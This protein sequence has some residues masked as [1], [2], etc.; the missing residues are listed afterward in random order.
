VNLDDLLAALDSGQVAGAALDVLPKEPPDPAMPILQHPRV[1]FTPHL[2]AS[3]D[4]A[5]EKVAEMIARQMSDYLGTGVITNAV[6]FPSISREIMEQL[7]PYLNLGERMGSLM[8]QLIRHLHDITITYSGEVAK[9]DTRP[10]THAVLKGLLGAYSDQPV[11]YVSA[12]S[13]ARDKGIKVQETLSRDSKDYTS[14]I[15]LKLEGHE[16]TLNDIWGTIFGKKNPRIVRLGRIYM[17]AMPEGPILVIQNHDK[18]G[19]IGNIGTTLSQHGIN[20]GR[21]QLGRRDG[22][23]LCL[24][25]IDTPVDEKV[26][27]EIRSLPNI[28]MVRQVRLD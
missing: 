22:Q 1:I 23:A 4:E 11:N 9:L 7:R 8:G 20:I 14:L 27:E 2:G 26:I 16:E 15:Q 21:F 24:V 28:I 19:V 10:L 6:N 18:P 17:D 13:L 3:T 25:N 12:P 5:Q